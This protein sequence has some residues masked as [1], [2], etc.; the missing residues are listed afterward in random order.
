MESSAIIYS[1]IHVSE[2]I[3]DCPWRSFLVKRDSN[4]ADRRLDNDLL[5]AQ[6]ECNN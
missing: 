2:K 1:G 6:C 5:A 4:F 3:G